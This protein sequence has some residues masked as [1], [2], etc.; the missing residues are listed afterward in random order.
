MI[1]Q[2]RKTGQHRTR[3]ATYCINIL[4][5]TNEAQKYNNRKVITLN[6]Q[7]QILQATKFCALNKTY[8]RQVSDV[9]KNTS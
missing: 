3:H 7:S 1:R 6:I 5:A 9:I 8:G 2:F 4:G